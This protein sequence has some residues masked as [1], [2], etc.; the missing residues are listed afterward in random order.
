MASKKPAPFPLRTKPHA[1]TSGGGEAELVIVVSANTGVVVTRFP[2]SRVARLGRGTD[3][4]VTIDDESVSRHHVSI[5]A[6]K[7]PIVVE[8][9]GRRATLSS[10]GSA[11]CLVYTQDDFAMDAAIQASIAAHVEDFLQRLARGRAPRVTGHDGLVGLRIAAAA[12]ES[13][14]SRRTIELPT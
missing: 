14:T 13:L 9:I 1:Y 10:Q 3:C 6:R 12:V 4:D 8:D 7:D 2:R 11:P 5:D